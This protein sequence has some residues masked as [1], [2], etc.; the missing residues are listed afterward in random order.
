MKLK[1]FAIVVAGFLTM[2]AASANTLTYQ[3]V[4]F[5]T[6][7]VDSD[8]M[9]LSIENALNATGNWAGI[10]Y[11]SAFEI[12]NL[13]GGGVASAA[14]VSGPGAFVA[15]VNNG[16]SA[17]SGCVTGGT[18]G[19]CFFSSPALA[20]TN[21]M[22]WII[23]FT[24]SSGVL[25]FSDPH[26]KVQFLTRAGDKKATGDLLS[27]NI[28]AVPEPETLAMLLAGLGLLGWRVRSNKLR[29]SDL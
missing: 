16:L 13:G 27:Q 12:K 15:N 2:A 14:V 6:W 7:A 11:L 18:P 19:A 23:D 10:G 8:T 21:S 3:G 22:T 17:N 26:L 5:N 28:P 1:K 20:L 9:G 24:P 25:D 29:A 4:T